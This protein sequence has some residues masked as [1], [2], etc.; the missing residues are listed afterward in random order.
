MAAEIIVGA[1]VVVA[2][3]FGIVRYM[4]RGASN[5]RVITVPEADPDAEPDKLFRGGIMGRQLLTSG[6]MVRMEFWDWGIRL[7]GVALV[8]KTIP[9]WEARY[10]ELALA[11]LVT[12]P[13]SRITVW[14]RLRGGEGAIGFLTQDHQQILEL[15]RKRDV[16]TSRVV[17]QVRRV[18][19]L[20][21]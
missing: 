18:D 19:E 15:L 20:Y 13:H 11:E 4:K 6:T 7:R 5:E 16:P 1:L 17:T 3:I 12:L 2:G 21:Q 8:R 14:L 9:V 10:D